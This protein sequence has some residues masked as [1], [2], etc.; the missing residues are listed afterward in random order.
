M[1]KPQD[2]F[3][4]AA[5]EDCDDYYKRTLITRLNDLSTGQILLVM[6]RL[7]D[8]DLTGRILRRKEDWHHLCLPAIAPK[9]DS[10]AIGASAV[11][12][13]KA[14]DL[15]HVDRFS[16]QALSERRKIMGTADFSAQ[17]LQDPAPADARLFA[18]SWFKR[19]VSPPQTGTVVQSWD[20]ALKGGPDNDY[21]V[22]VT[23]RLSERGV[24]ILDVYRGQISYIDLLAKAE[25]QA[26]CWRPDVL[27]IE[28][29]ASGPAIY[30]ALIRSQR[31]RGP[32][33]L[34]VPVAGGPGKE[35]RAASITPAVEAGD[36]CLPD[37][38]PWLEDFLDE[39][40]RFPGKPNDQVDAFVQLM[41]WRNQS[42]Y[43]VADPHGVT[44][45]SPWINV[46]APG[47]F[48]QY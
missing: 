48:D 33:P 3:S 41:A 23:A 13:V 43:P 30:E 9:A 7:H 4:E 20:T 39:V 31:Y 35:V 32:T 47:P 10:Y 19:Y 42:F 22:C 46:A 24:Y 44:R 18:R 40:T 12:E 21:S 17:Y 36:V 5:R 27:L 16:E 15:L 37:A 11:H 6:Q 8:D 28:D 2:A 29:A 38:A 26:A 14:G 34:L 1:L 25:E 45:V